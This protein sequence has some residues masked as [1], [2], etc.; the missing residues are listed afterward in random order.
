MLLHHMRCSHGS[1]VLDY[2]VWQVG[3]R[4]EVIASL[5]IHVL[6]LLNLIGIFF[7]WSLSTSSYPIS[8]H[9]SNFMSRVQYFLLFIHPMHYSIQFCFHVSHLISSMTP[10][11]LVLLLLPEDSEGAFMLH[12]TRSVIKSLASFALFLF[13]A[14]QQEASMIPLEVSFR[15]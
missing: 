13:N 8:F 12:L 7:S 1:L 10:L 2:N 3:I 4:L 6:C 14:Q 9:C 5:F 15:E 11:P